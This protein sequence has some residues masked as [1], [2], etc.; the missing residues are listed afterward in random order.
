[1]PPLDYPFADRDELVDTLFGHRVADPYRWLEDRDDVRTI[2][3]EAAQDYLVEPYLAGLPGRD[4]LRERLTAYLRAGSVSPP[5][6]RGGRAF[7]TRREPGQEHPVLLV[8]EPD[9][10]RPGY[11]GDFLGRR[12][13]TPAPPTPP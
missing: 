5:V 7:F 4:R 9:G 1:M 13:F 11:S 6:W 3:W 12:R 2:E 8:R 10:T